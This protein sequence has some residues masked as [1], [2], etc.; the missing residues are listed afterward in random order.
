[1]TDEELWGKRF[2]ELANKS[3]NSGIF[4]FTD[5]LGL[6]ELS[7]LAEISAKIRGI[8]YTAFGGVEGAERVIIRFGSVND[9]GY[10]L[11]FPIQMLQI[12]PTNRKFADKLSHR[13]FLG[14]LLNLGIERRCLGDILIIDNVGYVFVK[15]EIASFI[16]ENLSRIKHTDVKVTVSESLP[17]G[18][19]YK[20]KEVTVQIASER[21]DAVVAKVFSL[22]REESQ[23]LFFKGLVFVGGRRIENT[24]YTP[25]ENDKISVRG[26]GRMI[27]RGLSS[28][29]KKGKLNVTIELYV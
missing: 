26:Y 28:L 18:E 2:T 12:E 27:Y 8:P 21:L 22:S 1:M 10:E 9:L 23:R 16:A 13:D 3:Y 5:F 25:K 24:S 19:L 14:A 7:T 4:T 15:E 11:P 20:T 6:G 17:E 29:S